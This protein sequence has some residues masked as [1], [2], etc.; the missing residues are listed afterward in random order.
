MPELSNE[1]ILAGIEFP[2]NKWR[3]VGEPPNEKLLVCKNR[4]LVYIK[5][6][7]DLNM[8]LDDIKAMMSDLYWDAFVEH[9]KQVKESTGKSVREFFTD[10]AK[11]EMQREAPVTVKCK[12][13]D[14][15]LPVE[16]VKEFNGY[17]EACLG[18]GKNF[19]DPEGHG[20]AGL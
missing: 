14:V 8:P 4:M 16:E 12:G 3:S 13:C 1:D 15:Q 10:K 6:L 18:L 17:C 11:A 5:R 9:E 7:R 2:H 20:D 19:D